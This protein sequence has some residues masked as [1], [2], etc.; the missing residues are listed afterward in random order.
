MSS[1]I[2]LLAANKGEILEK[3]RALL[4]GKIFHILRYANGDVKVF[5][6]MSLLSKPEEKAISW[7]GSALAIEF[8]FGVSFYNEYERHRHKTVPQVR[9]EDDCVVIRY[10]SDA[11]ENTIDVYVITGDIPPAN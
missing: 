2:D 6:R 3:L 1:T 10:I 8:P 7:D 11:G 9:F 4:E 5:P